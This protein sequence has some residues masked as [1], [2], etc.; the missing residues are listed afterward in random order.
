MKKIFIILISILLIVLIKLNFNFFITTKMI[1]LNKYNYIV[2]KINYKK[3]LNST[4]SYLLSIID[5]YE[6]KLNSYETLLVNYELLKKEN[7]EL[8]KQLDNPRI[9]YTICYADVL[10][11]SNIYDYLIIN[12][13]KNKNIKVGNAVI[14]AGNFIGIVYKVENNI[15]RVK[16][17]NNM[18]YPVMVSSSNSYGQIDSYK[19]GYYYITKVDGDVKIGDH[20]VT[21]KYSM[22]IPSGLLI[23]IV[24]DITYDNLELSKTLKVKC[25]INYDIVGIII[26]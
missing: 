26:K 15:S 23:G 14:T 6:E 25:N 1:L 7:D 8:R 21:G 17:I 9:S 3:R 18:K 2:K 22:D 4:K 13:G 16:L 11:K 12:K 24:E 10:E 19:D 20:V 5:N